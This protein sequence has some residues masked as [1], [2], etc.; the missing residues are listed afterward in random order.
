MS[1]EHGGHGV[2]E[3]GGGGSRSGQHS[4]GVHETGAEGPPLGEGVGEEHRGLSQNPFV[5]LKSD[6]A[7]DPEASGACARRQRQPVAGYDVSL[8]ARSVSRTTSVMPTGARPDVSRNGPSC[9][10]DQL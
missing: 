2:R 7:R 1:V 3:L 10:L 5:A 9:V 6:D 8:A 4:E